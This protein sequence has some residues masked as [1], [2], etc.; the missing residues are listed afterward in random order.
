MRRYNG[1]L[2]KIAKMYGVT[3]EDAED[4]VQEVHIIALR[5]LKNFQHRSTYKTWVSKIMINKCLY[6]MKHGHFK[7][8]LFSGQSINETQ[9]P[10]HATNVPSDKRYDWPVPN[11]RK[12]KDED[13]ITSYY[14]SRKADNLS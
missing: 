1:A 7:K 9:K 14:K 13:S 8:E 11:N 4:L 6:K 2:Y 10:V 12:E 3:S 5:E